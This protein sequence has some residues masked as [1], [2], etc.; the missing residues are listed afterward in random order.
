MRV[1]FFC[2]FIAMALPAPGADVNDIDVEAITRAA[3]SHRP[4][5]VVLIGAPHSCD[6]SNGPGCTREVHVQIN[7]KGK[8]HW[9]AV[10]EISGLWQVSPSQLAEEERERD[11]AERM[12]EF[13]KQMREENK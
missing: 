3:T 5:D 7:S 11:L 12:A 6:R 9:V 13:Y 2:C 8:D 1:I 4:G 10:S